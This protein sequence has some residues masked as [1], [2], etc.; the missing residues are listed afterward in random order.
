RASYAQKVTRQLDAYLSACQLGITLASLGL[1]WVGEP[2][3]AHFVEPVLVSL[4]LPQSLATPVSLAI[5]FGFITFL[6]IVFGE[7]APK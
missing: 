5:A 6:H 4:N 1:G 2:A 7:L 3:V